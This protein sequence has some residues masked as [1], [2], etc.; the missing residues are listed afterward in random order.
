MEQQYLI[1]WAQP[2]SEISI[3]PWVF[4]TPELCG[5]RRAVQNSQ[6]PSALVPEILQ[7]ISQPATFHDVPAVVTGVWKS[8]VSSCAEIVSE[9]THSSC[10]YCSRKA[11]VPLQVGEPQLQ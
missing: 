8:E 6:G 4:I 1:F 2:V 11:T 5:D 3:A 9:A 7:N 10:D